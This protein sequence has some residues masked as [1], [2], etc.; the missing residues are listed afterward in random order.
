MHTSARRNRCL[1]KAF[2][3]VEIS[4]ALLVL[5]VGVLTA[6]AL[7]PEGLRAG[8]AATD[9]TQAALFSDMVFRSYRSAA[10]FVRWNDLNTYQVP[11][12]GEG[13]VWNG[14]TRTK[15]IY[16]NAGVQSY[17]NQAR[18]AGVDVDELAIRYR[19][20]IADIA[21]RIKGLTLHVWPGLF[22]AS[23]STA[24]AMSFYTE[25]YNTR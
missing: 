18:V 10:C 14:T 23:P 21:P 12:P 13:T 1:R 19:L 15:L 6:Y 8:K 2:T 4:L 11:V 25:I 3:L 5:S 24:D 22:G 17:R 7:F 20:D 16:P 9:E